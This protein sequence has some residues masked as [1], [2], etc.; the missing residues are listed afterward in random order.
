MAR[1]EGARAGAGNAARRKPRETRG[2]EWGRGSETQER[3]ARRAHMRTRKAVAES[4]APP[5][6]MS[7]TPPRRVSSAP[8]CTES[9]GPKGLRALSP[10]GD[11]RGLASQAACTSHV[12]FLPPLPPRTRTGGTASAPCP[13]A[14]CSSSACPSASRTASTARA[15]PASRTA[16]SLD[17][18]AAWPL[19]KRPH[20]GSGQALLATSTPLSCT[21]VGGC[22]SP[23]S[24]SS[25]SDVEVI[26]SLSH[27]E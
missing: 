19:S 8:P 1:R 17:S 27:L 11:G 15:A 9:L 13:P 12:V 18:T 20:S 5:P 21:L 6:Q 14:S 2:A 10:P 16:L 24:A 22:A 3:R 4:H 23:Q 7:T 26:S 25:A